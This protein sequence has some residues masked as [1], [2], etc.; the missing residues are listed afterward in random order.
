MKLIIEI[1][2]KQ[3]EF[4]KQGMSIKRVMEYPALMEAICEYIANGTP[5]HDNAT[6]WDYS[7][8]LCQ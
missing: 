5:I 8:F 4:I 3:Y 7:E 6:N 2:E 1:K